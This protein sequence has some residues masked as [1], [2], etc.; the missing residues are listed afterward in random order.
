[1]EGGKPGHVSWLGKSG[2]EERGKH[3]GDK[4]SKGAKIKG[5]IG[6]GGTRLLF[7]SKKS[8]LQQGHLEV[9]IVLRYGKINNGRRETRAC[10]LVG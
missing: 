5:A 6:N 9:A 1:M 8:R 2:L 7:I 3:E 10:K 4:G